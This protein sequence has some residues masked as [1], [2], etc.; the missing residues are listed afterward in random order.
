MLT[1][2]LP[3]ALTNSCHLPSTFTLC[4]GVA[5]GIAGWSI[6]EHSK[7]KPAVREWVLHVMLC[8][9]RIAD[10]KDAAGARRRARLSKV[11]DINMPLMNG[12]W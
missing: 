8:A 1:L 2:R 5:H 7:F 11:R 6:L 4:C 12:R 10:V 3:L 9:R